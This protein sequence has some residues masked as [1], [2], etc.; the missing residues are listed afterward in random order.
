MARDAYHVNMA[1]GQVTQVPGA[2]PEFTSAG[3]TTS[4]ANGYNAPESSKAGLGRVPI[5]TPRDRSPSSDPDESSTAEHTSRSSNNSDSDSDSSAQGRGSHQRREHS[6]FDVARLETEDEPNLG[7]HADTPGETDSSYRPSGKPKPKAP[8][9]KRRGRPPK[10]K[11]PAPAQTDQSA[12]EPEASPGRLD[13]RRAPGEAASAPAASAQQQHQN[14]R[15]ANHRATSTAE[16]QPAISL[17]QTHAPAFDPSAFLQGLSSLLS[18]PISEPNASQTPTMAETT[19]S[20]SA[21]LQN[22]KWR[23]EHALKMME[24]HPKLLDPTN[25]GGWAKDVENA[26]TQ[27]GLWNVLWQPPPGPRARNYD[28]WVMRDFWIKSVMTLNIEKGPMD[29]VTTSS[30]GEELTAAETW[31]T[32]KAAYSRSGTSEVQALWNNFL[33]TTLSSSKSVSDFANSLAETNAAL[34]RINQAYKL[35]P[36]LVNLHFLNNL[37]DSFE[38]WVQTQVAAQPDIIASDP[39]QAIELRTLARGAVEVE[40]RLRT[41][42]ANA[43]K[44]AAAS[45]AQTAQHCSRCPNKTNHTSETCWILHPE[46]RTKRKFN[47][48]RGDRNS[49]RGGRSSSKRPRPEPGNFDAAVIDTCVA[50][51]E[52]ADSAPTAE[53]LNANNLPKSAAK[54]PNWYIDSGAIRHIAWDKSAFTALYEMANPVY[55]KGIGGLLLCR[56]SGSVKIQIDVAGTERSFTVHDVIYAPHASFNLLSTK[57]L[58]AAAGLRMIFD[59]DEIQIVRRSTGLLVAMGVSPGKDDLYRLTTATDSSQLPSLAAYH[60]VLPAHVTGEIWHKRTGHLSSDHLRAM[61]DATKGMELVTVGDHLLGNCEPCRLGKQARRNFRTPHERSKTPF[62]RIYSD[63]SG[64]HPLSHRGERY[65]ISFLDDCTRWE[66]VAILKH[67]SD[68]VAAIAAFFAEVQ[69]QHK[70]AVRFFHTDNGGEFINNKLKAMAAAEGWVHETTAPYNPEQNGPAERIN[71]TNWDIARALLHTGALADALWPELIRTAAYLHNRSPTRTL[72][73]ITPFEALYKEKPSVAHLRVIG[74]L[75]YATTPDSGRKKLDPKA[76]RCILLGYGASNQYR[77]WMESSRRLQTV[78]DVRF[79]EDEF[80]LNPGIRPQVSANEE[81]PPPDQALQQR[82]IGQPA[83]KAAH[84]PMNIQPQRPHTPPE[85]PEGPPSKR[86]RSRFQIAIA[87]STTGWQDYLDDVQ[88]PLISDVLEEIQATVARLELTHQPHRRPTAISA[89]IASIECLQ[90]TAEHVLAEPPELDEPTYKQ[91]IR[92]ARCKEWRQGMQEEYNSL[93]ECRTWD[94]IPASSVPADARTLRGRWVLRVKRGPGGSITRY[95]ARWVVRGFEQRYGIDFNET[96]AAVVKPMT[97]KAIFSIAAMNDW[98]VE[99]MDVKTA[100]LYG[101]I[102]EAVYVELPDGFTQEGKVCRLRKALYGLKQAPRIWYQ[103]LAGF[104]KE[105]GYKHLHEDHSIFV[106]PDH[107]TII[108]V[109]VDDLLI[110]GPSSPSIHDLKAALSKKFQ[111]SDLGAVAYYLGIEITRDRP[112]R[113]LQLGQQTYIDKI[114]SEFGASQLRDSLHPFRSDLF[115]VPA[116]PDDPVSKPDF[117]TRYQAAV[118]SLMYLMLGTRP[119]LAFAVSQV[120]RFSANPQATHWEAVQTLF[121]YIKATR[122]L[123]LTF[124]G[125]DLLGYTDS[126]Y[127][128]DADRRSIGGYIFKLGGAAISWSSKRQATVSLST[129][130]AEYI[131][132]SEAA[133]EAIWLRRL[134]T[135]LGHPIQSVTIKADNRGAIALGANPLNHS[136]SK[137]IDVRWHFVREKVAEGLIKLEYI[138]TADM[139]ADGC[140]KPLV[141]NKLAKFTRDL[142]LE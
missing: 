2:P 38:L 3:S 124:R 61:K 129:C 43:L 52:Y 49:R 45:S 29:V 77:V 64:P 59:A 47:S 67:K 50:E 135:E 89:L 56:H 116:T 122:D 31:T 51:L 17:P 28:E 105:L 140:T 107:R 125:G 128:M 41:S 142:G 13:R 88:E 90:Y 63:L 8:T 114:V 76:E 42:A 62:E 82:V 4:R 121:R 9:G 103:T 119:D 86:T 34:S 16:L 141:G 87:D 132:Q 10:A 44:V 20:T 131:A 19:T 66:M 136:R 100:F 37:G 133:K 106:H 6:H 5:I 113:V 127:A 126:N 102:D 75:G 58:T 18:P 25:Y 109:Y 35:P 68:A 80:P 12:R 134:L 14:S 72:N 1:T 36:W 32:L 15:P 70:A 54:D 84:K 57:R 24:G 26:L 99:Q 46:L 78:R 7:N 118:G 27:A 108:A 93:M 71:R 120:S 104:L 85:A 81:A 91:A 33:D 22:V 23:Y 92:S 30:N 101:P 74:C 69:R 95:K 48:D 137:H 123:K 60:T 130:E 115:L 53:I 112:N 138:G 65:Y 94:V 55:L 117:R 40:T 83:E 111:M 11:Q 98:D 139:V 79:H 110:T 96:F 39:Q 97:Y 73:F 21:S